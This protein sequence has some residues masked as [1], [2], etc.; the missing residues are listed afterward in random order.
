MLSYLARLIVAIA[1]LACA[2]AL[3]VFVPRAN[4]RARRI[5]RANRRAATG[6]LFL[7]ALFAMPLRAQDFAPPSPVGAPFDFVGAI[8]AI[9]GA[10]LALCFCARLIIVALT[11]YLAR[12]A[13]KQ[14]QAPFPL[15][16]RP[17]RPTGAMR[18]A[19]G[20]LARR[21]RGA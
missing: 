14:Q 3:V 7:S 5:N 8:G 6:A 11:S 10:T 12:S 13:R 18:P 2:R 21:L 16:V 9:L 15:P 19:R 4:R 1:R 20:N 17:A